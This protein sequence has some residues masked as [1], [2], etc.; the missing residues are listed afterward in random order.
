[1]EHGICKLCREDKPLCS[2]HIIPEFLYRPLYDDNHRAIEVS[3]IPKKAHLLQ[4]GYREPLLCFECEQ[5]INKYEV[6]FRDIWY[7][8][9]KLPP[10]V[11][12]QY[13]EINGIDY[14][15]FKLF[16]LSIVWRAS[17]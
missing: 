17:V 10:V 15:L 3:L 1:M 13:V 2:S 16:H 14:T 4:K 6:Y 8:K 12:R 5:R 9:K 11:M 7:E